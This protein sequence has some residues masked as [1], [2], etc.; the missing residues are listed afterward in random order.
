[1]SMETKE[2]AQAVFDAVAAALEELDHRTSPASGER[3]S[4]TVRKASELLRTATQEEEEPSEVPA[5]DTADVPITV[6]D[7]SQ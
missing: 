1:M 4:P 3:P 2:K 5:A 6:G 7:L